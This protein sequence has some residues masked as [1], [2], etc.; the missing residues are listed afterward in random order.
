VATRFNDPLRATEI[1]RGLIKPAFVSNIE[2]SSSNNQTLDRS[3]TNKCP[4]ENVKPRWTTRNTATKEIVALLR[5]ISLTL[6][7]ARRL[8]TTLHRNRPPLD[9]VYKKNP[10][11]I[12]KTLEGVRQTGAWQTGA[13]H[14]AMLCNASGC[15]IIFTLHCEAMLP[16]VLLRSR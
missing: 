4:V 11:I 13:W 6:L 2:L 5:M 16:K 10:L 14:F 12:S 9:F 1:K 15:P 8:E 3:E 7:T